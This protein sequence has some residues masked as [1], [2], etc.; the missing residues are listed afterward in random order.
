M[1]HF[2]VDTV[3]KQCNNNI[4]KLMEELHFLE[5]VSG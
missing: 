4:E 5:M 2:Q 1:I 3:R